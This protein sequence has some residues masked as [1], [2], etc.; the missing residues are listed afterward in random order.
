M[1]GRPRACRSRCSVASACACDNRLP[2][3]YLAAAIVFKD[4]TIRKDEPVV[5]RPQA[6]EVLETP[7]PLEG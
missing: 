5:N 6:H 2:G 4:G 3:H 7:P 1:R